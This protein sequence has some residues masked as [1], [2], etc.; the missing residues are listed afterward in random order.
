MF[1]LNK[2]LFLQLLFYKQYYS[3]KHRNNLINKFHSNSSLS[4]IHNDCI[5]FKFNIKNFNSLQNIVTSK[6]ITTAFTN[7]LNNEIINENFIINS[8][9]HHNT[10]LETDILYFTVITISII[11]QINNSN[12]INKKLNNFERFSYTK[13]RT[14]F[15]LFILAIVFTRN[16]ENAI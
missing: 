4:M 6:A 7:R 15:Y 14:N 8:I 2:V 9:F 10:H 1:F 12:I 13:R 3:F 16:I 5:L 11:Y